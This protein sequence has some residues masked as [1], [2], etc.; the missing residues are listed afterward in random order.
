[1]ST[2]ATHMTDRSIS[3]PRSAGSEF[4]VGQAMN[5]AIVVLSRNMLPFCIVTGIAAL[6]SVF[7]FGDM[8]GNLTTP[9]QV[10]A[11]AFSALITV[12]LNAI[13]QAVILYA[14]F[15]D[16]RGRPI[17][18]AASLQVGFRRVL[19]VIG[20][21]LLVGIGAG[22]GMVLLLVPGLILFTMWYVSTPSCVVER[23][24]PVASM[25]RSAE[26]T[27]GH[28]WKV[29]GMF[30]LVAI[31]GGI[32]SGIVLGVMTAAGVTIGTVLNLIWAAVF[33]A[34]SAVLVVVTYHDLRVDKEGVDTDQI[35]AVFE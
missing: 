21:G 15:E 9:N 1:M 11:F 4:R 31:I 35:A 30:I 17:N 7:I 29:F 32:G 33:G 2:E 24:G 34:Y 8:R 13:S 25:R 20:V 10:T 28:R 22:L 18:I 6:P 5:K 16:M 14:A 26:L 19:P 12:V 3:A 27:K 23:L